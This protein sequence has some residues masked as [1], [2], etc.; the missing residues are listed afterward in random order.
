[1]GSPSAACYAVAISGLTSTLTLSMTIEPP[2]VSFKPSYSPFY[3]SKRP[4]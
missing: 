4:A 2:P 1:M 3:S